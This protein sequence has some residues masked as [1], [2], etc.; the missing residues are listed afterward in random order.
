MFHVPTP[1]NEGRPNHVHKRAPN[2]RKGPDF[3]PHRPRLRGKSAHLP[4]KSN[5]G[6]WKVF[7]SDDPPAI[8]LAV[9][10]LNLEHTNTCELTWKNIFPYF[11]VAILVLSETDPVRL[12]MNGTRHKGHAVEGLDEAPGNHKPQ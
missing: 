11:P 6:L 5:E 1:S 8:L 2:R 4:T 9:Q 3:G 12:R 7:K 10:T